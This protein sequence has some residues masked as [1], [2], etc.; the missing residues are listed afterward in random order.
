MSESTVESWINSHPHAAWTRR[1]ELQ[2][3]STMETDSTQAAYPVRIEV[4]TPAKFKR[5]QL[6]VRLLV[7]TWLGSR[8][9]PSSGPEFLD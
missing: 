9:S 1:G 2:V 3:R 6:L 4:Q 5:V 7:L 8:Q